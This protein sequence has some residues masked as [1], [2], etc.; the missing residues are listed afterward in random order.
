MGSLLG[1]GNKKSQAQVD[2]EKRQA[3]EAAKLKNQEEKRIAAAGRKRQGRAS[4]ISGAE[5]G[6]RSETLG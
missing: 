3:D 6:E 1:G 2:A 4:L 5:T